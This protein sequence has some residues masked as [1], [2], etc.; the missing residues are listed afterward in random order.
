MKKTILLIFLGLISCENSLKQ[1]R[2][3]GAIFGTTYSVIYE[4]KDDF[5]L[6]FENIF[7]AINRS[8]STYI[9][10]SIISKV[11]TNR[12]TT[13]DAHFK[14]V[15]EGSK[16][17]FEATEG[18]FDPTIGAVV[19]AWDF[20]PEGKIEQL[21]SLKIK[22]L[23]QSVGLDKVTLDGFQITKPIATK[24]D[25]NAIA[26]GYAVDK[27]ADFL[28]SKNASNFLVEIGGEIV[29]RGI[30]SKKNTPWIIG[31]QNPNIESE[32]PFLDTVVLNDK[33]MATSGTY[34]K[35]KIDENGRRYTHIID[36]NTG[37]PSRTNILSVSVIAENCMTADAY[38]TALQTM[39]MN[40]I[41]K[42]LLAHTELKVFIVF[43]N[44]NK[45]LEFKSFNGFQSN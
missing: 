39:P 31:I 42:F 32:I 17:I 19:N 6:E 43:E 29:C 37:Y 25:F 26:K 40:R 20:G 45:E 44:E 36:T 13:I 30:N 34:R 7:N 9:P 8:M 18:R 38:A 10:N 33:A 23:M 11:N 28:S 14:T 27:I 5:Q 24:L 21:D 1:H 22:D 16:Q 4:S 35:F 15:L 41:S 12:S 3:S 2:S